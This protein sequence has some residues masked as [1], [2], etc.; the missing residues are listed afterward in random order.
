MSLCVNAML[1]GYP[2]VH[3]RVAE[4]QS[5]TLHPV[6]RYSQTTC[7]DK[8]LSSREGSH[9]RSLFAIDA[10]ILPPFPLPASPPF[11]R[12]TGSAGSVQVVK[13]HEEEWSFI[14]VGGP[15]PVPGQ[16]IAAFGAAANLVHP[17]TG[18]PLLHTLAV[19]GSIFPG[20]I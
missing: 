11:G 6:N 17:A 5:V 10:E 18:A 20:S 2:T 3:D 4:Q 13:T 12:K 7:L 8:W 15:L 14:P 16:N 9:E 1:N 19:A